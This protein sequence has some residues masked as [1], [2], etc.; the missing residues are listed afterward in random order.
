MSFLRHR[1]FFAHF[2]CHSGLFVGRGSPGGGAFGGRRVKLCQGG[3]CR[4]SR[5]DRVTSIVVCRTAVLLYLSRATGPCS[6]ASRSWPGTVCAASF[7]QRT[8]RS[9]HG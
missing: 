8:L 1:T 2:S 9:W 4:R 3:V 5:P 6:R 7:M